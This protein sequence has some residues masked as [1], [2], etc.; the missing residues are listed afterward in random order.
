[1]PSSPLRVADDVR[2]SFG[3]TRALNGASLQVLPGAVLA[4]MRLPGVRRAR[5]ERPA[6]GLLAQLEVAGVA[7]TRPGQTSGG[8]GQRVLVA[9]EAR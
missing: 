1:M 5:V 6:A 2:K 7:G 3:V 8:P 9:E 4:L